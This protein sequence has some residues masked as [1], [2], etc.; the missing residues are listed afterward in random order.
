MKRPA[1]L[2]FVFLAFSAQPLAA[3]ED[4]AGTFK[5]TDQNE[6]HSCSIAGYNGASTD[7]WTVTHEVSGAAYTGKGRNAHGEFTVEG[8]I[9]GNT[10]TGVYSG[11]NRLN[12]PWQGEFTATLEGDTL[13]FAGKGSVGGGSGCKFLSE[14]TAKKS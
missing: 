13:K 4:F 10:A 14:V 11:V 6:V 3:P 8:K 12:V 5:G 9:S 7:P 1:S 2:L